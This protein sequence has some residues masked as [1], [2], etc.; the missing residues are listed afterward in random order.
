[1]GQPPTC[2][3]YVT[4]DS[5][6]ILCAICVVHL[7]LGLSLRWCSKSQLTPSILANEGYALNLWSE[8]LTRE[9]I[10]KPQKSYAVSEE[11]GMPTFSQNIQ[12]QGGQWP[13]LDAPDQ[14]CLP[15]EA[16][17]EY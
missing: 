7:F 11:A 5:S 6:E 12:F 8:H 4:G 1:M 16:R 3:E 17:V 2:L 13:D 10:N 9:E 14:L 15:S